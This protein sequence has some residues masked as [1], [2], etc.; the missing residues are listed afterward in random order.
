[1]GI[2]WTISTIS[3]LSG[4]SRGVPNRGFGSGPGE[5]SGSGPVGDIYYA[6]GFLIRLSRVWSE[7]LLF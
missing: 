3:L 2:E 4:G 7:I 5:G 6:S 1:M